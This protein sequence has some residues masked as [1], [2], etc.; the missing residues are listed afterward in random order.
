[1]TPPAPELRSGMV[2]LGEVALHVVEAGPADGPAVVLLHGFPEFWRGWRRQIPA[3]AA[4]GY[5]L[6]VPDQRGYNLSDKPRRIA[7]YA[8][9]TLVDDVERL[10]DRLDIGRA[11]V[12][13]HDWGGVVAW[14]LA[15]R[16]PSRLSR[17]AVL[18]APHPAVAWRFV[19]HDPVQRR[20]SWYIYFFQLPW[21]P[22]IWYGRDDFRLAERSLR[23]TARPGTFDDDDLAAYREAWSRPGALTAA[24]HWY[25]AA[26][27]HRPR[28]LDRRITVPTLL[29]WGRRDRFLDPRLAEA[30]CE[31]CDDVRLEMLDRAGHWLQ[32]EEPETVDR[33]LLE[34]LAG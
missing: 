16:R 28:R 26:L 24:I 22:E 18:N 13:G 29:L 21:L 3:L 32:H 27:W 30:N 10:L 1:M 20:K 15:A 25:R 6:V 23:A 14:W 9:D 5:R 2:D 12:V 34:H 7:A 17:L 19:L 8:L 4:A 33:L 11:A 31:F